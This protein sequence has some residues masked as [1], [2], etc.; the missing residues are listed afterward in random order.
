VRAALDLVTLP[1]D[2]RQVIW[3]VWYFVSGCMLAFSVLIIWT[4]FAFRRGHL[5]ALAVPIVIA[6]L[7][8]VT[9]LSSYA[10]QH[11]SFWLLF[12]AEGVVLLG[13][14]LSLRG[15]VAKST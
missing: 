10:A 13:A 9:G 4:W 11:N 5:D 8:I 1:A 14:S 6:G 15:S 12:F 7:W 3:I 2:V